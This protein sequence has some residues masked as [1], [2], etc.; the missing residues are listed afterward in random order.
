M[1]QRI[2]FGE[3]SEFLKGLGHHLTDMTPT[4]IL[5]L[6]PLAALTVVFGLFPGLVLDLIHGSV[7]IVLSD[8]AREPAV[9]V[10]RAGAD[11]DRPA[12]PVHRR[13]PGLGRPDRPLRWRPAV[14][15]GRR[16]HPGR[17]RVVTAADLFVI[18]PLI[19]AVGT[20]IAI[21]LV[22]LILPGRSVPTIATALAGLAITAALTV[23]VG[24]TATTEPTTAFGGAYRLDALTT[25]LDLLFVSIVAMTI[26]FAPDYLAPRNLPVAEF[27]TVLVF[28]LSGAMLIAAS[29]DLLLL[30]LGLELMVLPGYL[31]AGYH[32]SDGYSTE[33]AIKY[34]L[35]GSFS[36]AIFLFGLAFIWGLTGLDAD[37]RRRQH[38]DPGRGRAGDVQPGPGDGLRLPHD[39][40]R[41]QDR[42]RAVPLLDAG[43][44][45][46]LA[47]AG[48]GL[49]LGR[50]ED[51]GVR[52]DPAAV[53]RGAGSDEGR[54]AAGRGRPRGHDD[55]ARQPRRPDPGQRQADAG[56]QLDR[57]H[58][59][60]AR[61]ARR[62]S[63]AGSA[64]GSRGSCSTA[65]PTRS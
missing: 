20:A 62:V 1:Y 45:P 44:V 27:A 53:R 2:I 28:A 4:E 39:G 32:K 42:R 15:R 7:S 40:R 24:S 34:F 33:G 29:A 19:G 13:A 65:R 5:T 46:G 11:R 22:D 30:F 10:A 6:A 12:D 56:L 3:L 31:L 55:D 18:L 43:R 26:V 35:L 57:P 59:L 58:R 9:A 37:R 8:A 41:V 38:P 50:A 47:D 17:G 61:R 54:L 25:F 36:S 64:R 48:D 51:R 14:G 16:D 23:A 21:L 52:A 60:H 49:S 63:P